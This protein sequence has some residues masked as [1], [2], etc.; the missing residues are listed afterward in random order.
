MKKIYIFGVISLMLLT[1]VLSGCQTAGEAKKL[2]MNNF[3]DCSVFGGSMI[4]ESKTGYENCLQKGYDKFCLIHRV[5][6][7][8]WYSGLNCNSG[9]EYENTYSGTLACV[10][11]PESGDYSF[12]QSPLQIRD[13]QPER[14]MHTNYRDEV[15]CCK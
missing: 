7:N 3:M 1:V 9:F 13:G 14:S 8:S 5:S 10:N 4:D 15:V 2:S 11:K 12:C 6:T